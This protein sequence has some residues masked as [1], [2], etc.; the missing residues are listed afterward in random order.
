MRIIALDHPARRREFKAPCDDVV[1]DHPL[2]HVRTPELLDGERPLDL[3]AVDLVS[4]GDEDVRGTHHPRLL[5]GAVETSVEEVDDGCP[6]FDDRPGILADKP[7]G[8]IDTPGGDQRGERV[9]DDPLPLHGSGQ[10]RCIHTPCV[11]HTLA[12]HGV[13]HQVCTP[14]VPRPPELLRQELKAA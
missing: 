3:V 13:E 6:S 11:G 10:R 7:G 8:R 2:R 14:R 5:K 4:E 1:G 12:R 9:E